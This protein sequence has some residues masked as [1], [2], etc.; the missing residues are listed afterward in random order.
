MLLLAMLWPTLNQAQ[1]MSP[2]AYWPAPTGTQV[3]TVG[4]SYVSGDIVPDPSL[5]VAGFDSDITTA[6]VGY[7]RSLD[8][9]GRSANLIVE[10]PYSDGETRTVHDELGLIDRDYRG[11]GDAAVTL[12]YNLLGAPAMDM[13]DFMELRRDPRSIVG[14][15]LKVV[16]P[17]GDYDDDRIV[18]VG[19]NRWAARAEI[20]SI[21][22]LRPKWLLEVAAGVWF[23]GDNDDFLGFNREQSEI[24]AVETHLIHRFGPGFWASL[25][26]NGYKGGRSKVNGRRLNDLQRDAKMGAT[27]VFPFAKKHAFKFSYHYG[28]V[29]DSDERF[30]VITASYQRLF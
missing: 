4:A 22:V 10:L 11:V 2:R 8:L 30:D 16:A 14:F 24:Y 20:G 29:N 9:F 15:S 7:L 5:P 18:N 3:L 25:D 13:K 17:T 6:F 21:F 28:S 12:S 23:F 19:A 27:V 26:L 1:E